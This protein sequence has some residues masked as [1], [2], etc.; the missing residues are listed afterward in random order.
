MFQLER[1]HFSMS[2][3]HSIVHHTL[4][5]KDKLKLQYKPLNVITVNVINWLM[6]L[7]L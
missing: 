7:L 3:L 2:T 6:L 5:T 1:E 4:V